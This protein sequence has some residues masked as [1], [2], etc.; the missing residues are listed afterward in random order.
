MRDRKYVSTFCDKIYSKMLQQTQMGCSLDEPVLTP[1]EF[2]GFFDELLSDYG[3]DVKQD[4]DLLKK[5][6]VENWPSLYK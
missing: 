1:R 5:S 6:M 4:L 3:V 2:S